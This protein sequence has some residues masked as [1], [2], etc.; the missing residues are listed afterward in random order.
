MPVSFQQIRS[1]IK[2]KGP[3]AVHRQKMLE[4][5]I[6]EAFALLKLYQNDLDSLHSL[7]DRAAAVDADLRCAVPGAQPLTLTIPTPAAGLPLVILAADGSQINP[8]RHNQVEFG[9]INTGAVR[10]APG[11][12]PQEIVESKLLLG[13]DLQLAS[14]P[15]TEEFVALLRDLYERTLLAK[16]AEKETLPVVTL[17]DGQLELFRRP[18]QSREFDSRFD[19]YL[20]SL[21]RL[22][23]VQAVT[24]GYVDRPKGDLVV[25]LLELTM[26]SAADLQKVH[27]LRPLR[28]VL[29][30]FLFER[31]LGPGQRSTVFRILSSSSSKFPQDLALHFFYINVGDERRT[32]LARVEIPAWVAQ[33]DLLLDRLH[34]ALIAQARPLSSRPYPYAI[35]RAHEVAVVRLEEK[36]Q[37]NDMIAQEYH[38]LGLPLGDRSNK[39][40][41]K[42]NSGKRTRHS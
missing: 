23:Q 20:E 35:H 11:E 10:F 26:V 16:L 8:D 36:D 42:D 29:D 13:D 31:I 5:R 39:Q 1:Q 30:A 28:W 37:I 18:E 24:A 14:G 19:E 27:Q 21:R 32:H 6:E 25:R 3:A 41:A 4:E 17:T 9:V 22:C 33:H 34:A 12:S 38:A 7:V 40:I 2:E 15:M